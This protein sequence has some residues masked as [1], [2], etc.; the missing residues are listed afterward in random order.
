M[1]DYNE[2]YY[3][4]LST[5]MLHLPARFLDDDR[6]EMAEMRRQQQE[7]L[8]VEVRLGSVFRYSDVLLI[9][10]DCT[11]H[12]GLGRTERVNQH[13]VQHSVEEV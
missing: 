12:D 7:I 13:N 9:M 4:C 1:V 3:A 10:T 11:A 6:K 2:F 5:Y 8:N